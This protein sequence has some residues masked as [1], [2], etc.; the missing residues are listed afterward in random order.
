MAGIHLILA[1]VVSGLLIR[2]RPEELGQAPYGET[3]DATQEAEAASLVR[4][5]VYQTPVDWG[6]GDALRT[7]SLWLL[8]AFTAA[9]LFTLNFLTLHQVAYL[10]D[11]RYS[12]MVAATTV[13]LLSGMTIIGQLASGALGTRF[14]GRYIA[15]VCLAGLAVGITILMNGKVLPLIYLHTVV[16]G[17][18]C[19][20]LMVLMPVLI[21]AYFGSANYAQIIGWTT[22]VSTIF[23]ASSPLLAALIFDN[24][25]SYTPVF[26][27]SLVFLGIGLVCAI[28]ARPPKPRVVMSDSAPH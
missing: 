7:P 4:S 14:E 1:V 3:T 16:S 19:G 11:L 9:T 23:S 5:Q 24:T 8:M 25:G 13:G 22:P 6:V 27:A 12:P 26:I 28:F 18:S 15:V 21:G 2:N 17:I 20:G 10:Q